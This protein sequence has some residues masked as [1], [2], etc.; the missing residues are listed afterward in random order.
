MVQRCNWP[1]GR[2]VECEPRMIDI[3]FLALSPLSGSGLEQPAH[4]HVPEFH[5]FKMKRIIFA[6]SFFPP[7]SLITTLPGGVTPE[8]PCKAVHLNTVA[9]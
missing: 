1:V 6:V 2:G 5:I 3:Q 7:V 4:F 8:K 9:F